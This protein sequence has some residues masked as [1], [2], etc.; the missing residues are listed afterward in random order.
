M[1]R[2]RRERGVR[3]PPD[4]PS[5]PQSPRHHLHPANRHAL[6]RA[7]HVGA[8]RHRDTRHHRGVAVT[9]AASQCSRS[10]PRGAQQHGK[11]PAKIQQPR[12]L[13]A[14]YAPRGAAPHQDRERPPA[15]SGAAGLQTPAANCSCAASRR[16]GPRLHQAAKQP[17]ARTNHQAASPPPGWPPWAR[18]PGTTAASR[19][20]RAR[21][22]RGVAV[23]LQR[24]TRRNC[25]GAVRS[26]APDTSP[27]QARPAGARRG[28]KAGRR[29]QRGTPRRGTR[30]RGRCGS[31]I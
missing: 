12:L 26:V 19:L 14:V 28:R 8:A 7:T 30:E 31:W 9:G 13:T 2:R 17:G 21:A 24:C 1:Q 18:R 22:P 29:R 25:G 5:Q 15:R 6:S 11:D 4:Q 3:E 27:T 16:Q 23:A 10:A 20:R